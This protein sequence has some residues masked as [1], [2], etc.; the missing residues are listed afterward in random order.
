ME[1]GRGVCWRSHVYTA[2]K[3]TVVRMAGVRGRACSRL[4]RGDLDPS[5]SDGRSQI[6]TSGLLT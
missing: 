2:Q 4:V 6:P 1:K 5:G 3:G